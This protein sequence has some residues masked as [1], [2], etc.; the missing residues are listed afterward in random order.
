MSEIKCLMTVSLNDFGIEGK[1]WNKVYDNFI[2]YYFSY[3]LRDNTLQNYIV[4]IP[5]MN[6]R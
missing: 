1:T 5:Y 2:T 4:I 6:N 3:Y